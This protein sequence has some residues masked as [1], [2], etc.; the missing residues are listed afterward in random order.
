MN[1]IEVGTFEGIP[2]L[3]MPLI[4]VYKNPSDYPN[5]YVAR[6]WDLNVATP[7]AV[8]EKSMEEI[9]KAI[10]MHMVYVEPYADDDPNIVAT[11]L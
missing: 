1:T 4:V 5:D 2:V 10:P 7:Y 6:L 11:F 8:V 3:Q 9:K